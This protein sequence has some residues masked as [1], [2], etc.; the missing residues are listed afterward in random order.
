MGGIKKYYVGLGLVAI[1]TLVLFAYVATKGAEYKRDK[2]VNETAVE[3]ADD[4][5]EYVRQQ[6]TIPSELSEAYSGDIPEEISFERQSSSQYRFCVNYSSASGPN[7]SAGDIVLRGFTGSFAS[8]YGYGDYQSNYT[9]S[10]LYVSEYSW[11]Q[12]EKCYEVE[13]NIYYG[14]SSSRYNSTR[15]NQSNIN[16]VCD[17]SYE[18]HDLYEDKCE[19]GVYQYGN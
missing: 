9:P 18:Y 14:S 13:P 1:L 4:L 11:S 2:E 8:Q 15:S 19:D 6:R 5:N 16:Q 12:G 17:E 10:S 7:L 3:I